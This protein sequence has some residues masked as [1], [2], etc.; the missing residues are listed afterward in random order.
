MT[1]CRLPKKRFFFFFCKEMCT[2]ACGCTYLYVSAK[3]KYTSIHYSVWA[4]KKKKKNWYM[5]CTRECSGCAVWHAFC[6]VK[7]L[8]GPIVPGKRI[9]ISLAVHTALPISREFHRIRNQRLGYGNLSGYT[10]VC[11]HGIG[12]DLRSPI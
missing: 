3:T 4:F 12:I 2:E 8:T 9:R 5:R 11:D 10:K 7:P 1:L 6:A